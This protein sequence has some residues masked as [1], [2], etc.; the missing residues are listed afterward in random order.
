MSDEAFIDYI[1]KNVN[2]SLSSEEIEAVIDEVEDEYL[3]KRVNE[4]IEKYGSIEEL[5]K[6]CISHEEFIKGLGITEED[7]ENAEEDE[8]I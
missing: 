2:P 5:E 4:L 3:S 7:I 1:K 8:L 6:H